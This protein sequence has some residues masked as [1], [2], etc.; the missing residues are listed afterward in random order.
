MTAGRD[1][2]L[3]P[4]LSLFTDALRGQYGAV[5]STLR[6]AIECCPDDLWADESDGGPA[7]WRI[8]FHTLYSL[9]LYFADGRADFRPPSFHERWHEVLGSKLPHPP[10]NFERPSTVL[11]K[12]QLL[13]YLE[14][15]RDQCEQVLAGLTAERLAEES[16]FEWQRF[17]VAE[18]MVYN[19]RHAQHHVGQVHLL[20]R[21]R[22]GIESQWIGTAAL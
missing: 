19:I 1:D 7:V 5:F 14:E 16:P 22:G 9:G 8:A 4:M 20:L 2:I 18:L 6:A 3:M 17:T 21:R 11:T 15:L 13:G 10:Y 12:R